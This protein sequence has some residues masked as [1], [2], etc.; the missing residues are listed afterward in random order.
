MAGMIANADL[1]TLFDYWAGKRQGR[2]MPSRAD[3]D[4][5]E[6]LADCGR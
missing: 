3:I 4:P 2:P 5:V 6:R 1:Q